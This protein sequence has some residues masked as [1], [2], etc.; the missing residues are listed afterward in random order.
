MFDCLRS[1]GLIQLQK[2]YPHS[3]IKLR[4]SAHNT[5]CLQTSSHLLK[6]LVEFCLYVLHKNSNSQSHSWM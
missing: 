4:I 5:F 1:L 6:M 3:I 2:K